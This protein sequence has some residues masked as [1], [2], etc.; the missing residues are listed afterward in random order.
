[1]EPRTFDA[2]WLFTMGGVIQAGTEDSPL[3][4]CLTITLHGRRK[5]PE[6]PLYGNKVLGVRYGTLDLH[7]KPR[8]VSWTRLAST[9]MAGMTTITLQ[10]APDWVDGDVIVIATTSLDIAETEEHVVDSVSGT[11]VTLKDPLVYTHYAATEMFEAGMYMADMRAEVGLLTR[12]LK[13][14]G[15][16]FSEQDKN[17]AIVTIYSSGS[18]SSKGR[19]SNVEFYNVGQAYKVGRYPLHFYIMGSMDQSFIRS[20]TVHKSYNRAIALHGANGLRV[21]DNVAY[22][23]M[24]HAY[25]MEIGTERGNTLNHNLAVNIKRSWSLL[26][27]DQTPA[28]LWMRNGDNIVTNNAIAGAQGH[29]IWM[30]IP[31]KPYAPMYD[32]TFC[33]QEHKITNMDSNSAHSCERI[34]FLIQG[35]INPKKHPC[36]PFNY[37]MMDENYNPS[38]TSFIS[39]VN[40]WMNGWK[41]LYVENMGDVKLVNFMAADNIEI[42]LEIAQTRFTP[43]YTAMLRDAIV[44]ASSSNPASPTADTPS[45]GISTPR[46]E[47]FV[48]NGVYFN[49]F[50][51][52]EKAPIQTCSG[53]DQGDFLTDSGARTVTFANLTFSPD[54]TNRIHYIWP[55]RAILYDLDGSLTGWGN[56]SWA[57]PYHFHNL[58]EP[59]C[60]VSAIHDDGIICD[61]S[62]RVRRIALY[63]YAPNHF[64]Y[65][66]LR[67]L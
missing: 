37:D 12:C 4:C 5:D 19:I 14:Q 51:D 65:T 30:N 3:N 22:D 59:E 56:N 2:H 67:I 54:D 66:D 26:V 9:A 49:G 10:D 55:R 58:W 57:T 17:G 42:G 60:Q 48:V 45:K 34:G 28:G 61:G 16:G 23:I 53:C 6:I 39:N 40:T 33:P 41:G 20:S 24:G 44:I 46:T 21:E 64:H 8:M 43:D 62:V 32:P 15:D 29:C 18:N 47:N 31:E 50:F 35:A 38:K 36:K 7:G 1:M 11:V 13:V 25:F 52:N 63:N 27:T